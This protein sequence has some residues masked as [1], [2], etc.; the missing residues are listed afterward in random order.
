MIDERITVNSLKYDRTISR[1]WECSV[2]SR[3]DDLLVARGVFDLDLSHD[4]LGEIVK[5]TISQ[6][7]FWFGKW[8]NIFRFENPD[9]T[10]RNFYAN[11]CMPPGFSDGVL[12][13]VD[14]DIDILVWPDGLV[15]VADV[16]E[17]EKNASKFS[18]PS[19][20]ISNVEKTKRTLLKMIG[21]GEFPFVI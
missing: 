18:Y 9:R 14:L 3:N 13:Y 17:F 16:E 8:F 15:N 1:S 2:I 10:F 12:S 4:D 5:G 19:E 20:I 11:I 6:E 21:I 7:Y